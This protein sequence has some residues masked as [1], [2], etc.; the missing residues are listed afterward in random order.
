M[1]RKT[2]F[3]ICIFTII[4]IIAIITTASIGLIHIPIETV[5][6]II[7]SKFH[8]T[9]AE[10]IDPTAMITIT[11]LRLPRIIMSLLA[12]AALSICGV[13]FQSIFRNPICDPYMLGISSGASLGAV[14]AIILGIDTMIFGIT[15]FAF[16]SALITLF[17]ILAVTIFLKQNNTQTILLTGVAIN[18]FISAINT[19]LIV[20]KEHELSKIF[21][22]TMGSFAS[23]GYQ[24]ILLFTPLFILCIGFLFFFSKDLNIIQLGGNS[25][26]TLGINTKRI[27]PILLIITSLLIAGTVATCGVIG[28]VG[29]IVPQMTRLIWGNNNR[30]IMIFSLFLGAA[31]MLLADTL[32]RTINITSELPVG[33]I[34]AIIG[35]PYFIYLLLRQRKN[36]IYFNE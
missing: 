15:A 14:I 29:L 10:G 32:A 1:R 20:S 30:K 2:F 7:L 27:I 19:L 31:F 22:W 4:I 34:T 17:I 28:F 18:F 33:S 11:Q 16:I 9:S 6:Q 12:G 36:N 5:L 3:S 24:E 21:F 35:A 8:L 23:S 13:V 26:K 25:A